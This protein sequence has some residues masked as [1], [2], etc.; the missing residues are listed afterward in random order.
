MYS[1]KLKAAAGLLESCLR[2]AP[3]HMGPYSE[4]MGL[5]YHYRVKNSHS[6]QCRVKPHGG[7]IPKPRMSIGNK[8]CILGTPPPT[9]GL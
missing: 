3:S 9:S 4:T 8:S 7:G 5:M 6:F 2:S 1:L